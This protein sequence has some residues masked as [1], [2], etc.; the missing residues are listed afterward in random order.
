MSW[1][2]GTVHEKDVIVAD[3]QACVKAMTDVLVSFD[4]KAGTAALGYMVAC[5][6]ITMPKKSFDKVV[7]FYVGKIKT[8]ILDEIKNASPEKLKGIKDELMRQ[9]QKDR[10]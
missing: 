2:K 3:F 7:E 8:D 9:M 1:D 6:L 10:R 5:V 4:A